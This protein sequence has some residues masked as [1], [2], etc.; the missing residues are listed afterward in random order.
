V[1]VTHQ[2]REHAVASDFSGEPHASPGRELISGEEASIQARGNGVYPLCASSHARVTVFVVNIFFEFTRY[3]FCVD[4]SEPIIYDDQDK[5][6]L[7]NASGT[8][9]HR[10]CQCEGR[11]CASASA[12]ITTA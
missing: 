9:F 12:G 1:Q 6:F 3:V 4:S 2:Q 11:S 7:Q 8:L 5:S 10:E